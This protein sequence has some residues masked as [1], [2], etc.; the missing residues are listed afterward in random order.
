MNYPSV[1]TS[2]MKT[3]ISQ[4]RITTC[5]TAWLTKTSSIGVA[6]LTTL[7][8]ACDPP[9]NIGVTPLTPVGTFYTDT[10]TVRTSTVLADSVRTSL[11]DIYLAGRYSDPLFGKIEAS[12]YMR[13]A[14][15]FQLN[16]G[17]EAIY[18]SLVLYTPYNYTY[19]DTLSTQTLSV[20][21]LNEDLD[22]AKNYYNNSR[23]GYDATPLATQSFQPKPQSNGL[24]QF[25]LPDDLGRELFA[26]SGKTGGQTNTEFYKVL[27]GFALIP[28][29]ENTAVVGFPISNRTLNLRIWYHKTTDSTAVSF[30]I[31]A[32][33]GTDAGTSV[34][35]GFNRVT[36]DRSGTALENLQPLVPVPASSTGNRTF[37]QDALGIRTKIEIP[38]LKSLGN[39]G[40]I[41]INRAELS[42][43]PDLSAVESGLNMPP[44]LVLLETDATNRIFYG[45]LG[46]E[47]IVNNDASAYSTVP[48][49]QIALYD[50]KFKTFTWFLT[51]QLNAMITD[52]KKTNSFL[53][54]PVYTN[55]LG[56][57]GT[58]FQSQMNN[59]VSRLVMSGKPEDIKL[60]VFYTEAKE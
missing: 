31:Y 41:A 32:N 21:R 2:S 42:L 16:L 18:D 13:M 5:I 44:Y 45:T 9:G 48:D 23:I 43:K 51:T 53:V 12:A 6:A 57:G 8:F 33:L 56:Q 39:N 29:S 55:A 46:Y 11:P 60:I 15:E 50:T 20:H 3:I 10:L 14:L 17:E 27:K 19:G 36:A 47:A 34:R 58:R 4:K 49:P 54:A 59:R 52:Y 1:L 25:K 26:L 22:A 37:V 30:P 24:L 35:A 38:Y 7:L 40:P 28:G